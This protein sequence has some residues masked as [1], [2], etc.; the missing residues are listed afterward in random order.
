MQKKKMLRNLSEKLTAKFPATT[1][2]YSMAKI[3]SLDDAFSKVFE[4]E[5]RPIEGQSLQQKDKKGEKVKSY[6][7]ILIYAHA[8][9]KQSENVALVERK[10]CCHVAKNM[11]LAKSAG[12]QWVKLCTICVFIV[13][14]GQL[15]RLLQTLCQ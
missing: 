12:S 9:A 5:G 1:H 13:L 15:K 10:T 11:F 4:W 3:A 7:E 14:T 8:R 6:L 2:G